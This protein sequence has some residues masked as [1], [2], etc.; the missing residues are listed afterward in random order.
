M[1]VNSRS[2]SCIGDSLIKTN[3]DNLII[4]GDKTTKTTFVIF[5]LYE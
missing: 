3:I 1:F 2:G 4:S 5:D